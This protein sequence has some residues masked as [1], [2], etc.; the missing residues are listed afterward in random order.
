MNTKTDLQK[1]AKKVSEMFEIQ[2]RL[3][4]PKE[5]SFYCLKQKAP[6]WVKEMVQHAHGDMPPDD[7]KYDFIVE[8]LNALADTDDWDEI[9]LEP[10]VYNHDLLKW[11][12][13]NLTRAEY[14][15]D[16]VTEFGLDTKDFDL[17]KVLG[18]GQYIEK[19]E[20][21]SVVKDALTDRAAEEI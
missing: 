4:T 21:L 12:S 9:Q 14:V 20:V 5:E 11:V 1:L 10:D 13:S 8:A 17:F 2:Y 3:L 7:H 6:K 16:A 18:Y 15:N 19:Q